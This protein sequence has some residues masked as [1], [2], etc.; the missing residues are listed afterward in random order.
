MGRAALLSVSDRTGLVDF[1][2][3]LLKRGF[4]LLATS[5]TAKA[6]TE[7]S[8]PCTLVE[9]YTGSPEILDG[10]VK[11]LH[12]KIHAG[13]LAKRGVP[14]HE[15]ELLRHGVH[16][17][18]VV[19]VNLYPFL[20]HVGGPTANDPY[21]MIELIDVGGPALLRAAAKN[22]L[23]VFAVI[24]PADYP[25]VLN[26][27][28]AGGDAG[29]LKR[30]LAVK[31]FASL[32]N[33]N[34]EVAKYFSGLS[35]TGS[36][37]FREV[38]GA[39]LHRVQG[40][41][42]GENPHQQAGLYAPWGERKPHWKQLH[43]KE[44]SYNNLLDMQ[45]MIRLLAALPKESLWVAIVKHLNPCGVASAVDTSTALLRAKSCDSRSH[46]GGIIGCTRKVDL[47]TAQQIREDFAEIVIAPSYDEDA[48]SCLSQ[49]KTLRIVASPVGARGGI[50][51]RSVA[52]EFLLQS[53]DESSSTIEGAE[54]V[55]GRK[56]TST[57]V[58]DLGLA[59]SLMGQVRSNAIVVVRDQVSIG[60]GT[61]QMSRID[62]V[63]LA[64]RRAT[65]F[66]HDTKGAVAA[67]DAFFPFPDS[68]ET[69][70]NAGVTCIV[71]PSGA[72]RD[73]ESVAAANRL[74]VSLLFAPDRHFRH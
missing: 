65:H 21:A 46:F 24:D 28:D 54:L 25:T 36:E 8:I 35:R 10:R 44:L 38:E 1:A 31:V 23:G 29:P 47:K 64:L 51:M 9:E 60:I 15:E 32:A 73:D 11:T 19:A 30:E 6:L 66:G 72:K 39:V 16:S 45:A 5:G 61:G 13:I 74:G 3:G 26:A 22:H 37:Q 53:P 43:G 70:A 18:D 17:I 4:T 48:L 41:R 27:L 71:A 42:Y 34:L 49:S 69:L 56:P 58:R 20:K 12:P 33:D 63:E 68:I 57:E 59:W 7:E 40:L 14:A 62:S 67:S 52:N 50:E 2:R 55:S